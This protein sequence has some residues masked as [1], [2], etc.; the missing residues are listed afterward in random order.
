MNEQPELTDK[1][2]FKTACELAFHKVISHAA[3]NCFNRMRRLAGKQRLKV[4]FSELWL[5]EKMQ[6]TPKTIRQWLRSLENGR[7]LTTTRAPR[8]IW[9]TF[10]P[11]YSRTWAS[12]CE[13]TYQPPER[14]TKKQGKTGSPT[15][16]SA[17]EARPEQRMPAPVDT[18][19]AVKSVS[20]AKPSQ[21]KSVPVALVTPIAPKAVCP[22]PEET[23]KSLFDE[24]VIKA[25][26]SLKDI[27]QAYGACIS[28]LSD[29]YGPLS[30]VCESLRSK[31]HEYLNDN[32]TPRP[33]II[34]EKELEE[35]PF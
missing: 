6:T 22:T 1:S 5:A 21:S 32:F 16:E 4:E 35:A 20:E 31:Y 29:K 3:A 2:G 24:I 19:P 33:E 11:D 18:A 10:E 15:K 7:M 30:N 27:G 25:G 12:L 14:S 17:A 26:P 13:G 34:G 9:V 8:S 28:D 23:V